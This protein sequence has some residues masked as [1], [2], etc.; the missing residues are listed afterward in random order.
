VR[1]LGR[2]EMPD[3]EGED[4][5]GELVPALERLELLL[6]AEPEE[7]DFFRLS[8]ACAS[9]KSTTAIPMIIRSANV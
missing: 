2:E 5:R 4:T 7:D 8:L 9:G 6:D 3:R 1:L